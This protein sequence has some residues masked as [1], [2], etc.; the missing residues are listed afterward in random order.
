LKKKVLK[1]ND[2][3]SF[4]SLDTFLEKIIHNQIIMEEANSFQNLGPQT[5]VSLPIRLFIFFEQLKQLA[6][7]LRE[8]LLEVKKLNM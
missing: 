6:I 8:F 1:L 5:T 4:E 7:R 3:T 2:I